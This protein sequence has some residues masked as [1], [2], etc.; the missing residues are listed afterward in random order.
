MFLR[1]HPLSRSG[2]PRRLAARLSLLMT[3]VLLAVLVPAAAAQAAANVMT[4]PVGGQITSGCG[5]SARPDHDGLDIG[6]NYVPVTAAYGGTAYQKSDPAGWGRYLE[7]VHPN[8]YMTRYAHL[9][10]YQVG[11]GASVS[12]GQVIGTSGGRPG[13][14]GAGNSRGPH[15]HFDLLRNGAYL[16]NEINKGAPV[17]GDPVTQG[18]PMQANVDLPAG[19]S[20]GYIASTNAAGAIFI[21]QGYWGSWTR[22]TA[23]GQSKAVAV[24]PDGT[25]FANVSTNNT[26]YVKDGL[27]G[28]WQAHTGVGDSQAVALGP[29]GMVAHVNGCGSIWIKTTLWGAWQQ[30]TGCGQSKAVSVAPNGQ[31][32]GNVAPGNTLFAKNQL[33]GT[34]TQH[35]ALGDS[36]AAAVNG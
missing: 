34:W 20:A 27:W 10:A 31:W 12:Q 4:W 25:K 17:Y 2:L 33:W 21:K 26:L 30:H 6:V 22:H 24:S 32:I 19:S 11:N 3:T 18:N 16:C 5:L 23:D 7:I 13:A 36:M 28:A 29:N 35:T 1:S 8:G 14:D 9:S 15:L